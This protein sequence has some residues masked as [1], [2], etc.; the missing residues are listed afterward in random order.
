MKKIFLIT[1]LFLAVVLSVLAETPAF[2]GAYGGGMYATGGRGGKVLYV[3]SLA[4][5]GSEGTLRW[6]LSQKYPRIVM[7]KVS[8]TI[9]LTRKISIKEGNLTIAGQSAPGDGICIR[10]HEITVNADNVIVRFLRFRLGNRDLENESDAIGGRYTKNVII[11]HCSISWS[12][13]ECASF[14]DNEDFTLQWCIISESLNNAG[15]AKGAHG[16]GGIWGGKNA[17]FHHNLLAHHN[18]RN[19]RFNGWKRSGLKYKSQNDE[20]R[21]DFRNNVIFNWGDNASYGGESAG[22]YN[23]VANYYKAGPATKVSKKYVITQ[24]DMDKDPKEVPPGHGFYYVADNYMY[25]GDPVKGNDWK[26]MTYASGVKK[27]EARKDVAFECTPILQH[28]PE[29]AFKW[30]LAYAGASLYR[31]EIDLRIVQETMT[32]RPRFKGSVTGRSGIIDTPEDVGG[33][34]VYYAEEPPIDSDND[35]I[36][37]DWFEK[38]YPG[39][40]ANDLDE[41]GYTYLEVY[42]N[43]IV[44]EITQN[45]YIGAKL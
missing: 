41:S 10:D 36:P 4:D 27:K 33:Y 39:K 9:A 29:E 44:A 31:D 38:N 30:V 43:S 19:P 8:G 11:D 20:E 22:K 1:T 45:Q 25:D 14:Y 34:P 3:T 16:Y 32:G 37:D 12:I 13:D 42:L 18:S 5:D 28:A 15:H 24:V 26:Y 6:A 21:V 40:T 35:G 2:P 17:S 7:F 23:I